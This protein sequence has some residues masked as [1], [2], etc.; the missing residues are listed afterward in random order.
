MISTLIVEPFDET[1]TVVLVPVRRRAT[2]AGAGSSSSSECGTG[3]RLE[4]PT[5][6]SAV[7]C[8][9][10]GEA[11]ADAVTFACCLPMEGGALVLFT[12]TVS[13]TTVG[14]GTAYGVA[15]LGGTMRPL[16]S[17]SLCVSTSGSLCVAASS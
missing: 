10:D 17:K 1:D 5:C 3:A 14:V 15:A 7:G 4:T 2:G 13:M 8:T 12:S 11:V 6:S 16:A 9:L